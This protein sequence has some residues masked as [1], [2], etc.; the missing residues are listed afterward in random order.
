MNKSE[1]VEYMI[2]EIE[3]I[4]RK[5][6]AD[7]LSIE[8]TKYKKEVTESILKVLKGVVLTDENK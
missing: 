3:E 2:K 1:A 6:K 4:E 8:P 5:R 7:Y